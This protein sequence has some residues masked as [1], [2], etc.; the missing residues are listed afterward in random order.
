MT[1][2]RREIKYQLTYAEYLVVQTR[3]ASILDYDKNANSGGYSVR[4]IYFDDLKET[5]YREKIDG[6]FDR[7][8]YRVRTYNNNPGIINLECKEKYNR[9]ISKKSARINE[10]ICENLLR[11]DFS[12]LQNWEQDIAREFYVNAKESGLRPVICVD[13]HR[14]AFVYPASNLRITFDKYLRASGLAGF[15]IVK[16]EEKEELSVPVYQNNSVI[17]EIKFDDFMPE[18][19]RAVIPHETG[20]SLAVSKYRLCMSIAKT[21]RV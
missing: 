16:P 3:I 20:K 17:M 7:R 21:L 1:K 2:G 6:I 8:K 19:V 14:E 13:Y 5:A 12:L 15:S 9:W 10:E 4:S 18:I 11:G